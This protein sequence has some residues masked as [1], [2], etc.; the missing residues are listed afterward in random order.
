[1]HARTFCMREKDTEIPHCLCH[2]RLL[3][4]VLTRV[5]HTEKL[6]PLRCGLCILGS[7][8]GV[9]LYHFF[10]SFLLFLS[11]D[12]FSFME[13]VDHRFWCESAQFWSCLGPAFR[14]CD[15]SFEMEHIIP[16]SFEYL[17]TRSGAFGKR[18]LAMKGGLGNGKRFRGGG[19]L[20]TE[21]FL[22][23]VDVPDIASVTLILGGYSQ[24]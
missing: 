16:T 20:P 3:F 14:I 8:R 24:R 19:W 10:F 6:I 9:L 2:F 17:F 23:H 13:D 11:F 15:L 1:M 4:F 21:V 22:E 5:T 7:L 18:R 12:F